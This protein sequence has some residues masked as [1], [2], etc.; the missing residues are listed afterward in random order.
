MNFP[1][2]KCSA[3]TEFDGSHI[4]GDGVSVKCYECK[5]HFWVARESFARRALREKTKALC[6]SCNNEL[7]NYLDCP[8]CGAMYPDICV[9][10]LSKPVTKKQRKTSATIG[11]SITPERRTRSFAAA[12]PSEKSPKSLLTIIALVIVV[13]LA[14]AAIGIPYMNKKA[15]KTYSDG[16]FRALYLL[17]MS[18]DYNFQLCE[19]LS[20]DANATGQNPAFLVTEKDKSGLNSAK[21]DIDLLM[22]R[23][24]KPPQTYSKVNDNLV[25]LYGIY[26]QSYTLVSAPAGSLPAF[27][28]SATTLENEYRKA[29]QELKGSMPSKMSERLKELSNKYKQLENL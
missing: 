23:V 7:G 4:P 13:A 26:T 3:K 10:Q 5:T 25:K 2:P 1:C 12:Q 21:N 19:K 17:K 9:V 28:N 20:A 24:S 22:G 27:T 15:E 6:A 14:G 18:T 11:F 29:T 16:F 8:T